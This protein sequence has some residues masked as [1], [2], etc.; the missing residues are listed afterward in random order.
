MLKLS[1][2]LQAIARY[3]TPGHKIADIG[4]DH[5]LLPVYL[6]Q[7]GKAP[8]AIAGELNQGPLLAA[9]KQ[10][11]SAGLSGRIDV[12]QGDGISVL[13]PGEVD[14]VT[15][16]GMGGALMRDILEAGYRAGKLEGV[17]ELVLQPNIGEELVRGWLLAREWALCAEFI[18]EEDGKIYEILH[19]V[20]DEQ[21][22]AGQSRL[23]EGAE[24]DL[25][26]EQPLLSFVIQKMGPHLL[27]APSA[28]LFKKWEL[29]LKKLERI[30]RQLSLSEL[31]EAGEKLNQLNGEMTAIKEVL[32]CLQTDKR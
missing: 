16:A 21:L 24:L 20:K 29:E 6:V 4:S 8:S 9:R 3:V 25:K 7:S 30:A 15:I 1:N 5:A 2:R 14:T 26:L 28:V 22:Q 32:A 23:Y 31:P 12:R 19:A 13:Q 10:V 17:R 18:L 27:R 11:A